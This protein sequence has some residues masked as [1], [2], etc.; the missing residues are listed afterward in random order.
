MFKARPDLGFLAQAMDIWAQST[1]LP[2]FE[3]FLVALGM[4]FLGTFDP[5]FAAMTSLLSF[6]ERPHRP[7]WS[8]EVLDQLFLVLEDECAPV[9]GSPWAQRADP[10]LELAPG[11]VAPPP[12]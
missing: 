6:V 5:A 8:A 9:P 11:A 12:E 10:C 1:Y 7:T 2:F 3:G 4:S